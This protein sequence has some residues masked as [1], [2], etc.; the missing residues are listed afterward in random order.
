VLTFAGE[1]ERVLKAAVA[2]VQAAAERI[3]LREHRGVHPRIGAAD[4]VPFVPIQGCTLQDCV[5]LARHAA[6]EIWI[7]AGVPVYLYEASATRPE[8]RRLENI[9]RGG[10]EALLVEAP[11][12]PK[13]APDVG[14]PHLHPTAGAVVVGARKV[15]I[16]YNVN[17]QSQNVEIAKAI[18]AKIRESS[19]GL[20]CVKALGLPLVSRNQVQVSVNLTDYEVTPLHV[21]YEAIG[22]EAKAMGVEVA[23]SELI[24]LL[25]RAV[26]EMAAAHYFRFENFE[27]QSVIENR[28]DALN[29]K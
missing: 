1:P 14:G 23:G 6:E 28:L 13:R 25:P 11:L 19:G 26:V 5:V 3:D 18:A 29:S 8:R 22:A 10:F 15:L 12:N 9:R 4:V 2:A 20:P 21:V 16:A 27:S 7:K 17:L 24:G